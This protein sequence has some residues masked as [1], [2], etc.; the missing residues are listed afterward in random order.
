[1]ALKSFCV[2]QKPTLIEIVFGSST[3]LYNLATTRVCQIIDEGAEQEWLKQQ[4]FFGNP[5]V[6][7]SALKLTFLRYKRC[8]SSFRF[9]M[10]SL[11]ASSL[12]PSN[13]I[14]AVFGISLKKFF[15]MLTPSTAF[16]KPV[17]KTV[18][19]KGKFHFYFNPFFNSIFLKLM[20]HFYFNPSILFPY[21]CYIYIYIYIGAFLSTCYLFLWLGRLYTVWR[22][23]AWSA[24]SGY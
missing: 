4:T 10:Q 14:L 13:I 9:L 23:T 16:E 11:N 18:I 24:A 21:V 1:M 8:T 12:H 20:F 19:L 17:K 6:T 5:V 15:R 2:S 3:E 7:L 22:G